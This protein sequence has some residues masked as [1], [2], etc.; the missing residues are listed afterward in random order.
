MKT[1]AASETALD[2][3]PTAWPVLGARLR[4]G[5][6]DAVLHELQQRYGHSGF[7]EAEPLIL[8]WSLWPQQPPPTALELDAL[9]R[10]LR[11]VGLRPVAFYGV[12]NAWQQRLLDLGLNRAEELHYGAAMTSEPHQ[13]VAQVPQETQPA[14]T[15]A[16]VVERP[17]RSGQQVYARGRDLVVLAMVN[18]GA[19]I[20]ADGHIHVY[21][22]LRGRALAGARGDGQARVFA[23]VFEPEL[24]S[25]AGVYQTAEHGWPERVRGRAAQVRLQHQDGRDT[26][27]FEALQ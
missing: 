20:I 19:E 10:A 3:R 12:A 21:A 8:D 27:L 4:G 7:F 22:P 5:S 13:A 17:L 1:S 9:L 23:L 24:V 26:L 14:P 16:L 15:S 25:V 6:I 18:P 2:I 11:E